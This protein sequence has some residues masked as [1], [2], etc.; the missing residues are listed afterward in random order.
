MNIRISEGQLRFRITREDLEKLLGG[1][2]LALALNLGEQSVS[3]IVEL[4]TS[5][6]PLTIE[7]QPLIWKLVVDKTALSM[8]AASL[9]SREGIEHEVLLGGTQLKLAL[10]VD[11]RRKR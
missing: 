9:P 1:T 11:V 6:Q 5:E 8:L 7:I 3:Y 10:E 2:A 4:A